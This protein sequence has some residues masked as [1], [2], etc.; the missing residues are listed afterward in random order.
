[1]EEKEERRRM[2][3]MFGRNRMEK[4]ELLFF[5]KWHSIDIVKC[6]RENIL[7]PTRNTTEGNKY[8]RNEKSRDEEG[9]KIERAEKEKIH[10]EGGRL[11]NG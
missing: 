2:T 9:E 3:K 11:K 1:M 5:F 7:I 10:K 6:L 8:F 4:K